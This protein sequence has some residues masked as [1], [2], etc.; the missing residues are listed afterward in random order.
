MKLRKN[1]YFALWYGI[2]ATEEVCPMSEHIYSQD[3][4]FAAV[5]PLSAL[6]GEG[7]DDLAAGPSGDI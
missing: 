5:L 3:E 7:V 1:F 6:T 4:I 2:I